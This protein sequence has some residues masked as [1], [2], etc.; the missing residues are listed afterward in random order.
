VLALVFL[1]VMMYRTVYLAELEAATP[2][3]DG[4]TG[5]F[6]PPPET[7]AG[8][9][10]PPPAPEDKPSDPEPQKKPPLNR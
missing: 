10:P 9:E 5:Q 8:H 6:A 3:D 4:G 1:F 7:S 2:V